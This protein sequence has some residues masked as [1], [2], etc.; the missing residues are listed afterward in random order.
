LLPVHALGDGFDHQVA[1]AQQRQVL[2]VIGG[3][4]QGRV[5]GHPQR[6]GLQL[7]QAVDGFERNTA[8]RPFLGGEVEQ[9]DRHLAVD[10]M[11]GDLRT[12]DP[13]AENGHLANLE[14]AHLSL[15]LTGIQNSAS[16]IAISGAT[17]ARALRIR[18]A[19]SGSSLAK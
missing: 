1:L 5:L 16:S 14:S 11:G 13:G 12:H 10:E 4:D 15:L 2:F 9:H 7:L 8:L 6:R 17:P 19:V 3:L 18:P